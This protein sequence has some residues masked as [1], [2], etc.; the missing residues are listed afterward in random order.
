MLAQTVVTRSAH[1]AVSK[2]SADALLAKA[3]IAQRANARSLLKTICEVNAIKLEGNDTLVGHTAGSERYF[4]DN[5]YNYTNQ[6]G[7]I[8]VD[9]NGRCSGRGESGRR[10]GYNAP[11]ETKMYKRVSH[12][13]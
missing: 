5:S 12:A 1:A 10:S 3:L 13:H 2:I 8:P 7:A 9:L 4:F 6:L 11:T